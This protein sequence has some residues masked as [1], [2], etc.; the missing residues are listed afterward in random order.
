MK[1]ELE[2]VQRLNEEFKDM[3]SQLASGSQDSSDTKQLQD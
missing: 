1:I 2:G 3:E